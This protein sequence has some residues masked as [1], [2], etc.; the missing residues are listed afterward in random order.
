MIPKFIA[1]AAFHQILFQESLLTTG[2]V[3]VLL[4]RPALGADEVTAM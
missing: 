3:P 1:E 4:I 2:I